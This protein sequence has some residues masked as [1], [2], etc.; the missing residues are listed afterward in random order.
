[1]SVHRPVRYDKGLPQVGL[2]G[3]HIFELLAVRCLP[4][5]RA[6]S[7]FLARF[8]STPQDHYV[9]GLPK[10]RRNPRSTFITACGSMSPPSSDR[11]PF[12][13]G[14]ERTL[15]APADLP[16][17]PLRC[18]S[19]HPRAIPVWHL[20]LRP[21]ATLATRSL[22]QGVALTRAQSALYIH[23]CLRSDVSPVVG[24]QALFRAGV[25]CSQG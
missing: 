13:F 20:K 10:E 14:Q 9:K 7:L 16:C 23:N 22:R 12:S 1:M 19:P 2:D 5:R 15:T 3:G 4:R 25:P 17:P 11:K 6:A 8:R 21:P 18:R 24:P